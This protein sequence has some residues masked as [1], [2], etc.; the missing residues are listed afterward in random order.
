MKLSQS[1]P[2]VFADLPP[3]LLDTKTEASNNNRS[4]QN[5]EHPTPSHV[6]L[7]PEIELVASSAVRRWTTL[8]MV[9]S[10]NAIK[11]HLYDELANTEA[12]LKEHG[13][14]RAALNSTSLRLKMLSDS[15]LEAQVV[16]TSFTITNTRPGNSKFR[17]II[18]AAQHDRNQFMI[19]YTQ[20]EAQDAALAIVTV[21]S[22]QIIFAIDPAFAL[23]RFFTSAFPPPSLA[24]EDYTAH[25]QIQE[26]SPQ[27][28][29]DF[30]VDLH[31]LSIS[32]LEDDGKADTQSIKLT[33]SQI[34]VSQQASR[35]HSTGKVWVLIFATYNRV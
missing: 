18:P 30:R 10:V 25:V 34:L 16:L 2:R 15:S 28:S 11:L 13:I 22:P 4:L 31:D 21:D 33:V 8:D 23:L 20:S 12:S 17:E 9:V 3:N 27:R 29:L 24:A 14:A 19:L 6:N 7:Q 32:V 35:V 5:S 1:L 26:D